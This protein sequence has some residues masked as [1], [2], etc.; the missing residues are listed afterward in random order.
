MPKPNVGT[1]WIPG[2]P[3]ETKVLLNRLN[4]QNAG[5]NCMGWRV[6]HKNTHDGKGQ[7]VTLAFDNAALEGLGRIQFRPIFGFG[8]IH[9][10]VKT[11]AG[12]DQS[13]GPQGTDVEVSPGEG[14]GDPKGLEC[15]SGVGATEPEPG[16]SGEMTPALKKPLP[17][18]QAATEKVAPP[19]QRKEASATGKDHKGPPRCKTARGPRRRRGAHRP[20]PN[21]AHKAI[22]HSRN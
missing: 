10:R 19:R 17:E 5:L 6:L 22:S 3:L 8:V 4:V 12:R 16:P 13:P 20:S 18:D 1:A 7:L 11:Q 14:I 2:P 21:V 9:I 15:S